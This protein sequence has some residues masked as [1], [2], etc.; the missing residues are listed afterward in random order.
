M[1]QRVLCTTAKENTWPD[2]EPVLFLGEW[3]RRH[4]RKTHWS[5]M[6][7]VVLPYHWDD[8]AKLY[9]DYLYLCDLHERLL[10]ELAVKLNVFTFYETAGDT[11]TMQCSAAT[12]AG[13]TGS[14]SPPTITSI[15]DSAGNTWTADLNVGG[16]STGYAQFWHAANIAGGLNTFAADYTGGSCVSSD[17]CAVVCNIQEWTGIGTAPT[18][19]STNSTSSV[20][21]DTGSIATSRA[22]ELLIAFMNVA[23]TTDSAAFE[24]PL[25][26]SW[27]SSGF[28]PLT[29]D[30][31]GSN[32]Q[33]LPAYQI[34]AATGTYSSTGAISQTFGWQGA[35]VAYVPGGG[36]ATRRPSLSPTPTPTLKP[37]TPTPTLTPA[38]TPAPTASQTPTPA[39]NPSPVA[40]VLRVSPSNISFGKVR[41]GA[42]RK[43][44][45]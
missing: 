38:P 2:D 1:V 41:V 36:P 30:S 34:T 4:S 10:R 31:E 25:V 39:P 45:P 5:R 11:L 20:S 44:R 23:S 28:T 24:V 27:P 33:A 15:S 7:A 16:A 19:D 43:P 21:L 42:P 12:N 29:Q 14:N 6:D 22:V 13:T 40:A 17:S 3:C 8:R 32:L 9:K 37:A 35:I 26:N 18:I